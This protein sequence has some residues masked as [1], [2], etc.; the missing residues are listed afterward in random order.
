MNN[1]TLLLP[2]GDIPNRLHINLLTQVTIEKRVLN[3]KLRH[4][5]MANICHDK[6]RTNSGHMDNMG[7]VS[8]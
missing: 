6:E 4:R 5:P 3:T 7:D 8:S 2:L 1:R